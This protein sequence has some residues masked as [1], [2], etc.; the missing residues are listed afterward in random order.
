VSLIHHFTGI[1]LLNTAEITGAINGVTMLKAPSGTLWYQPEVESF[2]CRE[3]KSFS[4]ADSASF[5]SPLLS[6]PAICSSVER[7]LEDRTPFAALAISNSLVRKIYVPNIA[8][9][10]L[11]IGTTTNTKAGRLLKKRGYKVNIEAPIPV[12][13]TKRATQ[14]CEVR[15]YNRSSWIERVN[16]FCH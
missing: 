1:Y 3:I 5:K 4:S 7:R 10:K 12:Q 6:N 8:E 16:P 13:K 11:A 14:G 9:K 15:N 2:S